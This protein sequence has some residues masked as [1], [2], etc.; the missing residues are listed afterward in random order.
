V[1]STDEPPSPPLLRVVHGGDPT[2]EEIAALVAAFAG[3]GDHAE[4][5]QPR[6]SGWA[7]RAWLLRRSLRHGPG[8]WAASGRPGR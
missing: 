5:A 6:R 2:A 3:R 8:R 1:T 4:P 7:D